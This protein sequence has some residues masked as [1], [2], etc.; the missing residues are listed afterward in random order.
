MTMR[1]G[2]LL[3][4]NEFL[5]RSICCRIARAKAFVGKSGV[6]AMKQ[7]QRFYIAQQQCTFDASIAGLQGRSVQRMYL[8]LLLRISFLQDVISQLGLQSKLGVT[9]LHHMQ[10]AFSELES[11]AEV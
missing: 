3:S 4:T 2:E 7:V 9:G 6:A 10:G 8:L 1:G 11:T 5:D